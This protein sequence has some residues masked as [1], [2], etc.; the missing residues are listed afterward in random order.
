MTNVYY[1]SAMSDDARRE[2]LYLGDIFVYSPTAAT[3]A[4]VEHAREMIETAFAP[5]DPRKVQ[6][7]LPVEHCVE[8][9]AQVK[10]RFIHHP[11]CKELIP[12]AL[13]ELGCDL[14]KTYFDV[15]RLRSAMPQ[16]Y[17]TSGIAYAFHPH[18]D[19]WY[20]APFF[21]LNWWLP[22]YELSPQ[23]CLAFHPR[24]F[25][26][27]VKN[28][29]A[30][31]NYYRWN[32]ENRGSAAQHVKAD[33]RVQPKAEEAMEL[34]PQIRIVP[35]PGA[36]ILFCGAQMHSTVPNTSGV[37]RYSVDFRTVNIDDAMNH[38]G[39]ANVDS[40]C[41][42][43]TM[44]DYLRATDLS[45]IPDSVVAMYDDGTERDGLLVYSPTQGA[46][47]SFMTNG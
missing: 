8:V 41:T 17:L 11:R 19:T 7:R 13:G 39:A 28:G 46:P 1:D 6:D 30:T 43:T 45:H 29:S 16:D 10:P 5:N 14:E 33:T 38:R 9:L 3:T 32:A 18:R 23:N 22:V 34:D 31:Y 4:L 2:R 12:A 20:S 21:Q 15:P 47:Q 25:D 42:G 37:C 24:Y 36:V 44:R 40:A 35:P 27:P 26:T